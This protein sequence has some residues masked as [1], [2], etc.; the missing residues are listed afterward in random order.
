[1]GAPGGGAIQ[2][3]GESWVKRLGEVCRKIVFEKVGEDEIYDRF[4]KKFRNEANG[5]DSEDEIGLNETMCTHELHDCK[6]GPQLPPKPTAKTA[7]EKSKKAKPGKAAA[8]KAKSADNAKVKLDANAKKKP[9]T[10][11]AQ[12]IETQSQGSTSGS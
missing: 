7:D 10:S 9:T 12:Q 3:G 8:K 5:V 6:V 4:Y 1:M 2:M 11:T